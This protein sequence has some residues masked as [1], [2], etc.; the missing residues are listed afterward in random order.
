MTSL[1]L[2][3]SVALAW[4]FEDE[5]SD[6]AEAVLKALSEGQE[7]TAPVIWSLEVCNVLVV[8]ERRGRLGQ[9][10]A[11]GFLTALA[12][13]PVKVEAAMSLAGLGAAVDRA[14]EYQLTVYDASYLALAIQRGLPIATLD[15]KLADAARK[16]GVGV[17]SAP[18]Q[19][20]P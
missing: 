15:S 4:F 1:V 7:A 19:G 16:S 13:L 14:R 6:Y 12:A 5:S 9:A 20:A 17:W 3:C 11:S 8:A 18:G 2:D 10:H